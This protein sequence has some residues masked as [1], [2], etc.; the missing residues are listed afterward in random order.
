MMLRLKN[1]AWRYLVWYHSGL[2]HFFPTRD[3]PPL[4]IR[5]RNNVAFG[6]NIGARII[7]KGMMFPH[8]APVP[9]AKHNSPRESRYGLIYGGTWMDILLTCTPDRELASGIIRL[10]VR[11]KQALRSDKFAV[12]PRQFIV[13]RYHSA[14]CMAVACERGNGCHATKT[15]G[16]S[17]ILLNPLKDARGERRCGSAGIGHLR[18]KYSRC[19]RPADHD[20][21]N[22]LSCSFVST[23]PVF[24]SF[25]QPDSEVRMHIS[26]VYYHSVSWR[27]FHVGALVASMSTNQ[28][29]SSQVSMKHS[30]LA[31]DEEIRK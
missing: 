5:L 25:F 8:A 1:E 15:E 2:A 18:I 31:T 9:S 23:G 22:N 7:P 29:G 19:R 17:A 14:L 24:L 12:L 20:S 16:V 3:P 27:G 13:T 6:P 11:L 30:N 21:R 10:C 26:S 4:T 28:S